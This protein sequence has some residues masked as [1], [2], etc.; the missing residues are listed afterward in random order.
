MSIDGWM[1]KQNVLYPHNGI[2]FSYKEEVLTHA[3]MLR[4]PENILL[5]Q[6]NQSQKAMNCRLRFYE[7]SGTD[8]STETV[9]EWRPRAGGEQLPMCE[10]FSCP[11]WCNRPERKLVMAAHLREHVKNHR[12]VHFKRLNFTE[13]ELYFKKAVIYS[14]FLKVSAWSAL[15]TLIYKLLLKWATPR[16]TMAGLF[17][18]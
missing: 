1:H 7:M 13:C 11:G 5:S 9:D 16:W 6:R 14:F 10:E 3:T 8:K 2:S 18:R 17:H 4:N 15:Q 12:T